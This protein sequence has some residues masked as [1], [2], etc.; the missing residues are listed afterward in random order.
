[1]KFGKKL[2]DAVDASNADWKPFFMDYKGLKKLIAS[3]VMKNTELDKE[4]VTNNP[5][6]KAGAL[7]DV[8]RQE[9]DTLIDTGLLSLQGHGCDIE[10]EEE[11]RERHNK[12]RKCLG[13]PMFS[14]FLLLKQELDKVNDFYLDKEEELIIAHQMLKST[15]INYIS[16]PEAAKVDW[17]SLKRQ[18]IDLHGNTVML[19]SYA[20]VNYTGFRKIL[21][22]L[23][24][25]TGSDVRRK[26]LQVVWGTPFFSLTILQGIVKEIEKLL[27]DLEQ[28]V[29][30]RYQTK[31][32][33]GKPNELVDK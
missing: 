11:N 22:K 7:K 25:K 21:K 32:I 30:C 28:V 20:T 10:E 19:E 2:L 31:V 8:S 27:S 18:L 29:M 1:M 24:K 33:S 15:V 9:T 16:S 3:S 26:Y 13:D 14:F 5:T 23:D 17:R 12:K 4:D 6:G